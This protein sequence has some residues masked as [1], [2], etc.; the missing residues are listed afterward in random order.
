ML[1]SEEVDYN[2]TSFFMETDM[3][4]N[5]LWKKNWDARLRNFDVLKEGSFILTGY[6][7]HLPEMY[8]V[9]F[10]SS[11]A[12]N[13]PQDTADV[14]TVDFEP[15]SDT[16]EEIEDIETSVQN[17]EG[18][19]VELN[20]YPNPFVNNINVKWSANTAVENVIVYSMKG[21]VI[22]QFNVSKYQNNISFE[23]GNWA[24]GTYIIATMFK[25]GK[26]LTE[27]VSKY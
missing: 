12:I 11:L 10:D 13:N 5:I 21:Q 17:I 4:G 18:V 20:F 24:S 7:N 3:D 6:K 19:D 25:D 27:K 22:A 15:N 8:V 16:A 1:G 14:D 23:A 26:T 9:K 2:C